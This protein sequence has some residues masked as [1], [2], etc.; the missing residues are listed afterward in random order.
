MM[1][2]IPASTLPALPSH[3]PVQICTA[4]EEGDHEQ[5]LSAERCVCPCHGVKPK[6][7][8]VAA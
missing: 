4:C 1:G 3:T 5:V 7:D 6:A 2:H 8:E